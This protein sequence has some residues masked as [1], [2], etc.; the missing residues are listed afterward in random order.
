MTSRV[1]PT[2]ERQLATTPLT[3]SPQWLRSRAMW[4]KAGGRRFKSDR[5]FTA[6]P[7]N[8]GWD[9]GELF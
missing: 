1:S 2:I 9:D 6:S 8:S 5:V 3:S 4:R 7:S